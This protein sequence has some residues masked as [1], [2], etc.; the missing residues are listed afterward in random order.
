MNSNPYASPRAPDT[1]NRP[2]MVEQ[3]LFAQVVFGLWAG[4]LFGGSF[5]AGGSVLLGLT[6]SALVGWHVLDVASFDQFL[7]TEI[8]A[9]IAGAICGLVPGSLIG[10][11][12]AFVCYTTK[13]TKRRCVLWMSILLSSATGVAVGLMASQLLSPPGDT[14]HLLMTMG[15]LV[16]IL[17]GGLGGLTLG[18]GILDFAQ[19]PDQSRSG[20][21]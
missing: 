20:Q 4:I 2:M 3:G 14:D 9:A 1:E 16:G 5:G 10:P 8:V 19:V 13:R 15:V 17:S 18:Q 11:A 21:A 12:V 6:S 7:V